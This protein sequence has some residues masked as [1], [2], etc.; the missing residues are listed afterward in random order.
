MSNQK[1]WRQHY[2]PMVAELIRHFM[3]KDPD[4]TMKRLRWELGRMNPG[5]YG[6]QKKTWASEATRQVNALTPEGQRKNRNKKLKGPV[7][8]T[9]KKLF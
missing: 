4:I 8:V 5:P 3:D 1:T 9:Q 6:H 7:T 2:A